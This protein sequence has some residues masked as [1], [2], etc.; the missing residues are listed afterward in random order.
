[1]ASPET[2]RIVFY[3]HQCWHALRHSNKDRAP[4]LYKYDESAI[5]G[6]EDH[7]QQALGLGAVVCNPVENKHTILKH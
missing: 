6:H 2:H 4:H 1:M 7:E 3:H 5:P